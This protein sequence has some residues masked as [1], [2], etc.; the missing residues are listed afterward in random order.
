MK[1][2]QHLHDQG[3]RLCLGNITRALLSNPTLK[4]YI[5]ELSVP[6]PTTATQI[7]WQEK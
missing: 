7:G 4:H 3:P 5:D 6:Y 2:T 1:T